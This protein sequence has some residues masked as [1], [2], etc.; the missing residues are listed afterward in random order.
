MH[1]KNVC[2]LRPHVVSINFLSEAS[3]RLSLVKHL[4]IN[5]LEMI[6]FFSCP[7]NLSA[8][9]EGAPRP[10]PIGQHDGGGL[11][12]LPRWSQVLVT[13]G[14]S[15]AGRLNQ[16]A[17]MLSQVVQVICIVFERSEVDL[18][19]SGDNSSSQTFFI[20][21]WPSARLYAFPSISLLPQV[22]R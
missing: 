22:I 14:S 7:K 10:R 4:H 21:D 13:L 20:H 9:P 17:D 5:C 11:H 8:G 18:F 15:H 6:A 3:D 1:V 12:K 2:T 19:A 16:G